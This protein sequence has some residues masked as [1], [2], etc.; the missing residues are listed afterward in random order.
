MAWRC[1]MNYGL[2]LKAVGSIW[3]FKIDQSISIIFKS[4]LYG[5]WV[6]NLILLFL[7]HSFAI[8]LLCIGQLSC[9]YRKLVFC[10]RSGSAHFSTAFK[11]TSVFTF[12][13]NSNIN[14]G[15]LWSYDTQLKTSAEYFPYLTV[16][17]KYLGSH[18]SAWCLRTFILPG[19]IA[20][21]ID[22]SDQRIFF[23]YSSDSC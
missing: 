2:E 11:Y 4:G 21:V 6:C 15:P 18:L 22:S 16:L 19:S 1:S 5:T 23:Q 14:K 12:Y 20:L 7:N 3:D 13:F 10:L 17:T 8:L 9:W